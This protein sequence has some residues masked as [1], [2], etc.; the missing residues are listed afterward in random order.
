MASRSGSPGVQRLTPKKRGGVG[1]EWWVVMG[2]SYL[3]NDRT[4]NNVL[5]TNMYAYE[6]VQIQFT[7]PFFRWRDH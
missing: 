6:N 1:Q 5:Q 4:Q 2:P 3:L 7:R